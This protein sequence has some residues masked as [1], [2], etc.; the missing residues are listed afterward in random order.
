MMRLSIVLASVLVLLGSFASGVEVVVDDYEYDSIQYDITEDELIK[1]LEEMDYD[2]SSNTKVQ[3]K[4][5]GSLSLAP[6]NH[7]KI[8]V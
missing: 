4:S 1:W 7:E 2:I 8:Y 5:I 3:G 6:A